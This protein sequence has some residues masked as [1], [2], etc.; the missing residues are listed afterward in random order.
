MNTNDENNSDGHTCHKPV[1]AASA[2]V[3]SLDDQVSTEAQ[4]HTVRHYKIF[5]E[6]NHNTIKQDKLSTEVKRA[7]VLFVHFLALIPV[8][9]WFTYLVNV[10]IFRFLFAFTVGLL[11]NVSCMYVRHKYLS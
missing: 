6:T 4:K 3:V 5:Y 8:Y 10:D 7:I 11:T 9:F 1:L 2:S